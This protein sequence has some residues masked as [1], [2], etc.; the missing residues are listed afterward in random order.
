[1]KTIQRAL[2]ALYGSLGGDSASLTNT[3]NIG[4]LICEIAKLGI[5]AQL[6][7]AGTKELP[8]FPE[9]DRTYTLQLVM[10]DGEATLSWEA[11]E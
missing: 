8:A 7:A 6:S 2:V 11:A 3:E 4:V 5:G 1:M 10:D 9:E